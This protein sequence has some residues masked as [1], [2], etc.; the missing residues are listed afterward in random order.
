[1]TGTI[2]DVK[3]LLKRFRTQIFG[4][5]MV[6]AQFE[7]IIS[8]H[9]GVKKHIPPHELFD[10][11]DNDQDGRIDGLELLGGLALCCQASFEEKARFCFELF[12]F[13]LNA[14]LSKKEMV[15]MMMSTL[16]G[17]NMLSGGGEELEMDLETFERLADDAFSRAD[18]DNSGA[19]T[20]DEFVL[21][22]RSNRE[23]MSGIERLNK[24]ALDAKLG[25]ESEDSAAD[26]DEGDMSDADAMV[27]LKALEVT[28]KSTIICA[29]EAHPSA[30]LNDR[31]DAWKSQIYEPIG[32]KRT[33]HRQSGPC[34]NMELEWAFGVASQSVKNSTRYIMSENSP[35]VPKSI[36]YVTAS[37]GVVCDIET[38]EQR[39]YQGHLEE[40]TAMA[41]HPSGRLIATVDT[42]A[43]INIWD[44]ITLSKVATISGV[45]KQGYQHLIFSPAGDRITTVGLDPDHTVT[46]YEFETAAVVS[47]GK[48]IPS[49]NNVNGIGYSRSG[50]EMAIVGK[51]TIIFFR[52]VHTK[53][54]ALD[55]VFGRIGHLG[56]KQTFFCVAYLDEDAI[57]SCA[58]GE[59][60][61]FKDHKC[62]EVVQAHGIKDPVLCM[63]FSMFDGCL[64]TGGK[65][66]LIKTWDPT[67]KEVGVAVD[68]A[69][70]LNGDGQADS[71]CFNT[72]I[73]SVQ[74]IGNRL[75]IATKGSDV[76][77]IIMPS[78][79]TS[80]INIKRVAWGH[81]VGEL[82][83]LSV[84]PFL[85]EFATSG[86]DKTL[87]TWDIRSHCEISMKRLP[88]ESSSV[89]YNNSG[90][91]ICIGLDDGSMML[92]TTTSL[93]TLSAWHHCDQCITDIKFSP[94][95]TF[96]AAACQDGNIYL[97]KSDDKRI[98]RRQAVCRGH[99][100]AVLHI[101]FSAVG[102]KIQSNGADGCIMYWDIMG[103]HVKSNASMKDATWATWT[104]T[105]GWPVQVLSYLIS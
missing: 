4:F 49:P 31:M 40:I 88:C 73:T 59:L 11:L 3:E 90:E 100:G 26:T 102:N 23:M 43:I 94:D 16:C 17:M 98:F 62:V 78:K 30:D 47:S 24:L 76:F 39:F 92:V 95:D 46:V 86:D 55:P 54:R 56:K 58:S 65:D 97:Y 57:V 12:D 103:N 101:D 32:Y 70:D 22:A 69:E 50:T 15:M 7:S 71:G 99:T 63:H 84:H 105:Y 19:I 83:G 13:N 87:R 37:L 20:Y 41:L 34:T 2:Q 75:L 8:F 5:A 68:I 91:L 25:L 79:P 38:R 93:R 89:A 42:A 64:V 45:V 51:E 36:V 52:G 77:E 48:G 35:T 6:E 60:Y 80:R 44:A 85:D 33:K 27:P 96:I 10:I 82:N 1:M 72:T 18:R 74:L 66:G 21:W 104:C 14:S 81:S 67:L 9:K 28:K 53:S 29:A 61:R